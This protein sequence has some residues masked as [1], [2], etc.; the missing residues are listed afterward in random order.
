M[1]AAAGPGCGVRGGEQRADLLPGEEANG[2]VIVALAGMASTREMSPAC[3]G[4]C[5]DA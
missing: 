5:R 4:T 1:I 3:S 2:G